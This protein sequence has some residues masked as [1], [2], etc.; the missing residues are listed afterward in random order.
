MAE[1]LYF[2]LL[3]IESNSLSLIALCSLSECMQHRY[4]YI[5]MNKT[6]TE[7]QSY[8][9]E[10]YTDLATVNNMNDMKQLMRNVNKSLNAWIGLKN[11]GVYEW[12]WS[13]GDPVNY[14]NWKTNSDRYGD[15]SCV[16]MRNG[17]WSYKKW[18]QMSTFICYNGDKGYSY[19]NTVKTWNE[20]QRF[21]RENHTD[22]ASVRNQN[23]NE[24]I[25][26]IINDSEKSVWIGLF[27]DSW[28]WSDKSDSTFRHWKSGEP[29]GEVH[30]ACA[31]VKMKDQGQWNDARCN[32][33]E[34]FVCHEDKLVL[35]NQNLSWS[36]ALSYC[37]QNHVD[38]VSVDSKKIQRWV[39]ELVQQASTP[40]VWMGLRHSCSVGLWFWVNGE[41]VCYQNW[42][43]GNKTAVDDCDREVKSGAV[44]SEEDHR[45]IS[46]PQSKQLNF[47][48][49]RYE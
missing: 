37:R 8:C 39:S 41:M 20:S 40:A 1:T 7:A 35:I 22:L 42:T 25:Q 24:Q 17:T 36:D 6:W 48:C 5:D 10:H 2:R 26:K 44:Q 43:Q 23:E 49:I 45:W 4:H 28:E 29:S 31:E 12:K 38:L 13:M 16:F 18:D 32:Y 33:S 21:C 34:T 27:N 46:L 9:R 14:T 3:L 47:I 15:G 11:K 19:E 30:P